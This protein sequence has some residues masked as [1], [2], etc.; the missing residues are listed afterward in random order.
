[1]KK[2]LIFQFF[3]F[4]RQSFDKRRNGQ[5]RNFAKHSR[6]AKI[7]CQFGQHL[8]CENRLPMTGLSSLGALKSLPI[9]SIPYV[10]YGAVESS[11]E[12]Y[13]QR[14]HVHRHRHI[15]SFLFEKYQLPRTDT[16]KEI[17]TVVVRRML[18][19]NRAIYKLQMMTTDEC[20]IDA[21]CSEVLALGPSKCCMQS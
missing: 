20:S 4:M 18:N 8:W 19:E 11:T 5:A 10:F 14:G 12:I 3:L 15:T 9:P 17:W 13:Q 6:D 2:W 16:S 21:N 7:G 1:M